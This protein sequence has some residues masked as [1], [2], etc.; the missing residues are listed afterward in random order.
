LHQTWAARNSQPRVATLGLRNT[1]K[2]LAGL[3]PRTG[4]FAY[5][6]QAEYFNAETYI[7]FLDEILLPCFYRRNHRVYLIQDN[8]SY[9]KKSEVYDWFKANR[10]RLEVFQLPPYSPEFNGVEQIWRYTR[11]QSTHNRYFDTPE[12]L[13]QAL[14]AT[15][16]DIQRHPE[17]ILGLVSR[18]S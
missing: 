11:K 18:F 13:C 9:H 2:I 7:R 14:F 8:A 12:E 1:Q 10:K 17:S 5:R 16:D 15:F 6:H 3:D 4:K